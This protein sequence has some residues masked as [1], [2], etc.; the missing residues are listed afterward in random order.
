MLGKIASGIKTGLLKGLNGNP[1]GAQQQISQSEPEIDVSAVESFYF[2]F[3]KN[4]S[5][6]I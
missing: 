5:V 1:Q 3:M 2:S 6:E 4:S